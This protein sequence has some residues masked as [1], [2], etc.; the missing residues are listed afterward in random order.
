MSTSPPIGTFSGTTEKVSGA[1]SQAYTETS[2]LGQMAADKVDRSRRAAADGLD[3][4]AT[5]LHERADNLP[6][7]QKVAGA[8]HTVADALGSTAEYVRTND[9][10]SMLEDLQ[11]LVKKNP[12]PALLTAAVLGFLVAR[13]F[14]RN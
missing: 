6:G 8:A 9:L 4:A 13:T 3:S 5:A 11:Q 7:V 2:G 14:S 1:A 12:G 10:K